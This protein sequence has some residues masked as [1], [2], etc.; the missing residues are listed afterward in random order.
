MVVHQIHHSARIKESKELCIITVKRLKCHI[1]KVIFSF[2]VYFAA[3]SPST[4][5]T[6][7]LHDFTLRQK[8]HRLNCKQ[9]R[10][11]A[12]NI[13]PEKQKKKKG[14]KGI[15]SIQ[16]IYMQKKKKKGN[17]PHKKACALPLRVKMIKKRKVRENKHMNVSPPI[18][19]LASSTPT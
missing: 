5:C 6:H 7:P 3:A 18:T 2:V 13:A 1:Y 16:S 9:Q 4:S 14:G 15:K 17:Q 11:R 19:P 8:P 10:K 12:K